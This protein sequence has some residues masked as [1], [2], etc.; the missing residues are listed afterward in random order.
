VRGSPGL[1]GA[2]TPVTPPDAAAPADAPGSQ[3]RRRLTPVRAVLAAGLLAIVIAAVVV[4]AQ[5]EP[6]QAGTNLTADAGFAITLGPRQKLCEPEELLPGDTG[7]LRLNASTGGL[8]GPRLGVD[9]SSPSGP[10]SSG[11]LP[12]GWRS[13]EVLIP[14]SR[15]PQTLPS[16]TVCVSNLGSRPVAFGGSVPD[17]G[18]MIDVAGKPLSGRLRIEY[19]RPGSESWFALAPTLVHR[20][21]LA[22]AD[23]VRHWEWAVVIVLM[24]FAVALAT[25]TIAKEEPAP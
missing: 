23:L 19:M 24:L 11:V 17:S 21:S 16:T 8:P 12:A 13:G 1:G 14:L 3:H 4:L 7:A 2:S 20:F 25:F 6:R 22:K 5:S 9:I 10:V 18:F 15:V